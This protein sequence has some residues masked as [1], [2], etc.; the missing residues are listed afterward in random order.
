MIPFT[1]PTDEEFGKRYETMTSIVMDRINTLLEPEYRSDSDRDTG[2]V[3][4]MKRFV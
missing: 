3:A 1:R 4:G 2:T